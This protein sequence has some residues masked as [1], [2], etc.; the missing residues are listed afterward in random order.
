MVSSTSPSPAG[1]RSSSLRSGNEHDDAIPVRGL[2]LVS[3]ATNTKPRNHERDQKVQTSLAGR[4]RS[5]PALP[6]C[7]FNCNVKP[8]PIFL[9]RV[10]VFSWFRAGGGG[11]SLGSEE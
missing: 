4:Q 7:V 9:F 8:V 6:G 5:V 2:V 3:G 1:V 11:I 10:S